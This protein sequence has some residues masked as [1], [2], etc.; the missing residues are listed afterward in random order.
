MSSSAREQLANLLA[1]H[2]PQGTFSASRTAP[3]ADLDLEVRGVGRITLPVSQAQARQLCAVSRPAHYG[4]G[5]K[6]LV[7]RT[8]RD[9]W[10][11]P[12]S[13]VKIDKRRWD[14]TLVPVLDKLRSDLG[15]PASCELRAEL[16]SLL[17][18]APGQFFLPHQDSETSDAMVGSL[19]VSLPSTFTGGALQVHQGGRTASYRGSKTSLSFV[20]FYGDCRHEIKPVTSGFRVV[21][22]YDLVARGERRPTLGAA[23]STLVE[24]LAGHLDEH[25]A[26]T[27]APGRLV[28]LLD[29]EYTA[30]ALSWTRLKGDDARAAALVEAAANHADCE[31]VLALADAHETWSAYEPDRRSHWYGRSRSSDWDDDEDDDDDDDDSPTRRSE[32]DYVLDEL[33]ESEITLLSWIDSAGTSEDDL[34]LAVRDDEVCTSTPSEELQPYSSE[35]EGYMGNWGNTLDRWYHRGALVAWPRHRAFAIRAEASPSWAMD[36]LTAQLRAGDLAGARQAVASLEPFW[37]SVAGGTAAK[38]LFAKALRAA[39]LLDDPDLASLLV[40]PFRLE[41]L[42]RTHA[43]A[44]SALVD[45]YGETWTARTIARWSS[46]RRRA[47][48]ASSGDEEWMAALPGLCAALAQSGLAGSVGARLLLDHARSW[49]R[50]TVE[51]QL[52]QPSPSR[53]MRALSELGRPLAGI[54]QGAALVDVS[55]ASDEM[56]TLVCSERDETVRCAIAVLRATPPAEW[57]ANR[58]ELVAEHCRSTLGRLLARPQRS[59]DDWSIPAPPGCTCALCTELATYLVDPHRTIFEWPLRE[60]NRAHV[61]RRIDAAELPVT[62]RTRRSGRPYTLVLTKTDALFQREREIRDQLA[63]DLAWI[64]KARQRRPAR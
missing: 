59:R 30:R 34:E 16:H 47:L 22:T 61:H 21:L 43:K 56:V 1:D 25:F 6:T 36:T 52:D 35:Y 27:D 11:V 45:H 26:G 62:H 18:Y 51:S 37:E 64:E 2:T 46:T 39:R 60:D 54:F 50:E 63:A 5:E 4:R 24:Q 19:V 15:L 9:T 58:V 42:G 40:A 7:D 44:F 3:P 13:R 28:Y 32:E 33:V 23:D 53:R 49:A 41:T 14:Q 57:P 17:V 48:A 31:V 20:A 38:G 12:K 29:H 10:E 8:V 55:G